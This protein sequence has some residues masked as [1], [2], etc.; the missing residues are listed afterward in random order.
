MDAESTITS[1]F[2][3]FKISSSSIFG[4]QDK[5]CK[6]TENHGNFYQLSKKRMAFERLLLP[7]YISNCILQYL[8][9]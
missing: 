6:K 9:E 1:Y 7:E 8:I 2:D 3:A 5:F 4:I